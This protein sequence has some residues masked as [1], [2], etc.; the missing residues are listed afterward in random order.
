MFVKESGRNEQFL[1]RTFHGCFLPSFGSFDCLFW[2]EP[3][4][5][6]GH[7]IEVIVDRSINKELKHVSKLIGYSIIKCI[8]KKL[9]WGISYRDALLENIKIV[10]IMFRYPSFEYFETT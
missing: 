2:E 1:L 6:V 5:G 9:Y 3:L 4:R 10:N 8:L 7:W